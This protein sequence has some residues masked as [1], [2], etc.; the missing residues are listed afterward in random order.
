LSAAVHCNHQRQSVGRQDEAKGGKSASYAAT[1]P[2]SD[3][4]DEQH[5]ATNKTKTKSKPAL[6]E[7]GHLAGKAETSAE[8]LNV[9]SL[10][11]CMI[12]RGHYSA[13]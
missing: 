12:I 3:P 2:V 11:A 13:D 9:A 4:S 10:S 8:K 7:Q 6:H 5:N 1:T